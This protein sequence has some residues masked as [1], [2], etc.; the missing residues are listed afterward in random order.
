MRRIQE[1]ISRNVTLIGENTKVAGN[2]VSMS[3][4]E[5]LAKPFV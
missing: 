4:T 3:L 2:D 1:E 5:A